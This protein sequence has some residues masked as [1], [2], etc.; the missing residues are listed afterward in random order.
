MSSPKR[1][2]IAIGGSVMDVTCTPMEGAKLILKTSNPGKITLSN[3][4]VARNVC[5]VISRLLSSS[6]DA[7]HLPLNFITSVGLDA[8]GHSLK[9]HIRKDLRVQQPEKTILLNRNNRT[10]IYNCLMDDTGE[11]V[12]AVAD[13]SILTDVNTTKH[14]TN[15]LSHMIKEKRAPLIFLDSNSSVEAMN[16]IGRIIENTQAE[17][18]LDP[19]SVPKSKHAVLAG[20]LPLVTFIKPNEH[21]IFSIVECFLGRTINK[22]EISVEECLQILLTKAKVSHVLLTQVSMI[23]WTCNLLILS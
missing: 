23:T 7:K 5:E 22:N 3:G 16:N 21:E 10:A 15:T 6:L 1:E 11:L 12:A 14:I 17:L 4:G 13:M 8:F 19:T 2:I 9:E 18:Y 20:L